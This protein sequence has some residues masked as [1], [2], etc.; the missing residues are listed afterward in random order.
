MGRKFTQLKKHDR[1]VIQR[2]VNNG[3]TQSEIAKALGKHESTI[4]R[5]LNFKTV[6]RKNNRT[7]LVYTSL[8]AQTKRDEKRRKSR[9]KRLTKWDLEWRYRKFTLEKIEKHYSFDLI[10]KLGKQEFGNDFFSHQYLYDLARKGVLELPEDYP[11]SLQNNRKPNTKK[12][13]EHDKKASD[14]KKTYCDVIDNF[15]LKEH[16]QLNIWEIDLMEGSKEKNEYTF[17]ATNPSTR[18]VYM[19]DLTDKRANTV[20]KTIKNMMKQFKVDVLIP[21]NGTEF[22]KLYYF[23]LRGIKV[24]YTHVNAPWEK[25][26]VENTIKQIRQQFGI[27]KGEPFPNNWTALCKKIQNDYNNKPKIELNLLTPSYLYYKY[28]ELC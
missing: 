25:W 5:E 15:N 3:S 24:Y 21:D 22:N 27:K 8:G 6:Q 23:A 20:N 19:E 17:V 14:K 13:L 16:D 1:D 7:K 11:Y 26:Y 12:E 28:Q 9:R 10:A 2:M 4:S 18:M